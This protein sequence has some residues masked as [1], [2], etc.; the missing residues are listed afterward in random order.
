MCACTHRNELHAWLWKYVFGED[1]LADIYGSSASNTS[2]ITATTS[3]TSFGRTLHGVNTVV[4][5]SYAKEV[6]L[7]TV[8]DTYHKQII[9]LLEAYMLYSALRQ[10]RLHGIAVTTCT[11]NTAS[12]ER[13]TH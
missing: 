2:T 12:L 4:T 11:D 1:A 9:S 8:C 3:G 13:S 6:K 10:V 7:I 5:A